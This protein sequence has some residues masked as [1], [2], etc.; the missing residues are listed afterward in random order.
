LN[1]G[2]TVIELIGL[3]TNIG[4]LSVIGFLYFAYIKNLRSINE[5]KESQLKVAEQNVKLWKDRAFEFERRSPEFIEKQLSDRIKI[6]EEEIARLKS[7]ND[8]QSEKFVLKSSEL[9]KLKQSLDI[10][11]QFQIGIT[12]FDSDISDYIEV[13][14]SEIDVNY[15]GAVCVDAATLMICDPW[16]VTMGD[17]REREDFIE[18]KRMF[19]VIETGERF[20]ADDNED[21]WPS[22]AFAIDEEYSSIESLLRKGLIEEVKYEGQVPAVQSSYIKGDFRCETHGYLKVRHHT[23]LNGNV[24]AGLSV[25][26]RGDGVYYVTTESYKGEI[27][28]IVIDI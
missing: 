9:N 12:V 8:E 3:V 28:R 24:G 27:Q 1:K 7:D 17:E 23:F 16:Y 10:A 6:R 18:R 20:C 21:T 14:N 25:A 22:E 5:F 2:I 15:L 13:P 11:K 19:E 26:L 4:A